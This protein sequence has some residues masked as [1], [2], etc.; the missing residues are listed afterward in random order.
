MPPWNVHGSQRCGFLSLTPSFYLHTPKRITAGAFSRCPLCQSR[1][2]RIAP[3]LNQAVLSIL[4]TLW[5]FPLGLPMALVKDFFRPVFWQGGVVEP[6]RHSH[7]EAP[8]PPSPSVLGHTLVWSVGTKALGMWVFYGLG[9]QL[10]NGMRIREGPVKH[11]T[12]G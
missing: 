9:V 10:P 4:M 5:V 12:D 6:E 3:S 8:P 11:V 7:S 2:A 1:V